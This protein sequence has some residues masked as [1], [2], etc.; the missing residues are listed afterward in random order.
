MAS[1]FQYEQALLGRIVSRLKIADPSDPRFRELLMRMALLLEG[2]SKL[3]VRRNGLI[4][5]GRLLNSLHGVVRSRGNYHDITVYSQGVPY[6]E[7]YEKGINDDH[8][9]VK[10]HQMRLDHFWHTKIDPIVVQVRQH[11]RHM[12]VKAR[13]YVKPAID[14]M[15]DYIVEQLRLLIRGG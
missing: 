7:M 13:P 3:N 5:T 12:N 4:K 1:G 9:D 8:V 6:A 11:Q 14:K 10:T 15:R 2:E